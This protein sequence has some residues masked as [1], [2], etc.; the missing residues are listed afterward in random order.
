MDNDLLKNI[1]KIHTT[2]MGSERIKRNLEL[3]TDDVVNW[4][5]RKTEQADE[6][7]RKGKNWY[8][9]TENSIITINAHSYTVIT[10]H[11]NKQ[12]K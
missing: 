3:E 4:C 11:K 5:K 9:S 10:A 8:V 2:E 12:K 1:D 6:I 7:I